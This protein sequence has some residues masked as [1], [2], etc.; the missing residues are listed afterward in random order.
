MPPTIRVDDDVYA[1]LQNQARPF[2]DTPNSVLRRIANLE[3]PGVYRNQVRANSDTRGDREKLNQ[4]AYRAPILKILLAHGGEASRTE[5][6][7]GLETALAHQLTR[8]DKKIIESGAVRWQ[9]SAE[10]EVHEMRTEHLIRPVEE[11]PRG[12]WALTKKGEEA[13]HELP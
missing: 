10:F 8:H 9:K 7:S 2:E 13:A 1:W 12:V 5:V 11:A 4:K 6:L 3:K